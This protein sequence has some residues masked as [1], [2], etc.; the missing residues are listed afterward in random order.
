M[1][2]Y[3]IEAEVLCDD[4]AHILREMI[5]E[6]PDCRLTAFDPEMDNGGNADR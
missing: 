3:R 6:N 2:R 4:A 1:T 5:E